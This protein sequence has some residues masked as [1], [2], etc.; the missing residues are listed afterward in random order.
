MVSGGSVAVDWEALVGPLI[1]PTKVLI[2]EAMLCINCP[3][4]ARDLERV[5]EKRLGLSM[6]AV[7]YHMKELAKLGVLT[8]VEKRPV[9]GAWQKFYFFV[10]ADAD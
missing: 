3:L 6:S 4:S 9:R 2:I 7:S 1:H 5:F 10:G 8:L